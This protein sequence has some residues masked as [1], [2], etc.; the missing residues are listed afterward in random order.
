MLWCYVAAMM[1]R[2]DSESYELEAAEIVEH[3]DTEEEPCPF[4]ASVVGRK[5]SPEVRS[6]S[7]W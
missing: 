4:Y 1:D 7:L 2:I 5:L 3:D 6:R